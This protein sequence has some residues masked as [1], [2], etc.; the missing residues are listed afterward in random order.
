M[1]VRETGALTPRPGGGRI[2]NWSGG[3][4]LG[5]RL[6]R[7]EA[8]TGVARDS[9]GFAAHPRISVAHPSIGPR[10]GLA[11]GTAPQLRNLPH[12]FS[13]PWRCHAARHSLPFWVFGL[14][15]FLSLKD[16]TPRVPA[17]FPIGVS[18]LDPAI[19]PSSVPNSMGVGLDAVT[20]SCPR[21]GLVTVRVKTTSEFPTPIRHP[22]SPL[23]LSS[24]P[25]PFRP[26][27]G[28]FS[29]LGYH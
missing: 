19:R 1:F 4:S 5:S 14:L 24:C 29:S 12:R 3:R 16:P 21:K 27:G 25:L 15:D 23:V 7:S 22:G 26:G 8:P 28:H 6:A 18:C 11:L 9:L 2:W 20:P 10:S 13:L 17:H